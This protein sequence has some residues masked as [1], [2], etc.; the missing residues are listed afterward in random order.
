MFGRSVTRWKQY[1]HSFAAIK[2]CSNRYVN[3]SNV[4]TRKQITKDHFNLI[5][6]AMRLI[7]LCSPTWTGY[8]EDYVVQFDC[9]DTHSRVPAHID[10]NI[11]TQFCISFGQYVGGSLYVL[12]QHLNQYEKLDNH[13]RMIQF[14]GRNYHYVSN[15]T[16]G[17]IYSVV[18]FKKFYRRF[19]MKAFYPI[20]TVYT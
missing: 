15:D 5:Q 3:M 4:L 19:K 2:H 6:T 9:M 8:D 14:D 10:N 17:E 20:N 16:K 13:Q 18:Y 11:T 7:Y 1:G 12:N